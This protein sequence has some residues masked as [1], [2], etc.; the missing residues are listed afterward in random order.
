MRG[1]TQCRASRCGLRWSCTPIPF[2]AGHVASVDL[3]F[4]NH[5]R[6]CNWLVPAFVCSK[7]SLPTQS[8]QI[9]PDVKRAQHIAVGMP[10]LFLEQPI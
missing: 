2:R 4:G 6:Y 8:G 1:S 3:D 5:L 10:I 7:G 9:C